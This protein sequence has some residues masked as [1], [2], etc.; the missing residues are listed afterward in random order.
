MCCVLVTD[1]LFCSL[2]EGW[3][4]RWPSS[5]F[6]DVEAWD[7]IAQNRLLFFN[8]IQAVI[9]QQLQK[10]SNFEDGKTSIVSRLDAQRA[11]LYLEVAN[12]LIKHGA[13]DVSQVKEPAI[14]TCV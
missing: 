7:D 6:D 1:D 9:T 14:S 4:K 12:G 2:L 10:N 8:E 13:Y 3:Q 11:D 5:E